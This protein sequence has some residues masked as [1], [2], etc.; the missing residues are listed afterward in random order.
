MYKT[1]NLM[2]FTKKIQKTK[3]LLNKWFTQNIKNLVKTKEL[4]SSYTNLSRHFCNLNEKN[5]IVSK[6]ETSNILNLKKHSTK[7]YELSS[8][9][10]YDI[11]EKELNQRKIKIYQWLSIAANMTV[12]TV[13]FEQGYHPIALLFVWFSAS[14]IERLRAIIK[15]S[16]KIIHRITIKENLHEIEFFY[17]YSKNEYFVARIADIQPISLSKKTFKKAR[18]LYDDYSISLEQQEG[19]QSNQIEEDNE[20][21]YYFNIVDSKGRYHDNMI[22]TF[23]PELFYISN[24]YLLEDIFTQATGEVLKYQYKNNEETDK[25]E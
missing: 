1:N 22:L 25:V 10:I 16:K 6:P 7:N 23:K 13:F 24:M 5:P 4:T 2:F 8:Q 14:S 3:P 11:D 20:I 18:I 9:I 17:G 15:L 21:I 12:G 19:E